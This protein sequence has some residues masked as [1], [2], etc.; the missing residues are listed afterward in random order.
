MRSRIAC[1]LILS[2]IAGLNA[3]SPELSS[4]FA[5]E[6]SAVETI[7]GGTTTYTR[8]N[9]AID[10]SRMLAVGHKEG[11]VGG[12]EN[13]A[14]ELLSVPDGLLYFLLNGVCNSRNA[15]TT[16]FPSNYWS[17]FDDAVEN[18]PGTYTVTASESLKTL[19][20]VAGIPVSFSSVGTAGGYSIA[21]TFINYFNGNP[22]FSTFSLPAACNQFTCDSCYSS[23]V[24]S[25]GSL[26]LLILAIAVLYT[27]M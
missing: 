16:G 19:I 26:L 8:Y 3:E 6:G 18:P 4:S 9:I 5:F 14:F 22:P 24:A 2:L 10:V 17:V 11:T 1:V 7:N 15:T 20:T 25:T 21:I 13:S 23:A 27:V 12:E